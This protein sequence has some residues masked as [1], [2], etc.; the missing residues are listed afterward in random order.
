MIEGIL[1]RRVETR[2]RVND[3][4]LPYDEKVWI[5][6]YGLLLYGHFV[7]NRQQTY[8]EIVY[9]GK[10]R[11]Y[12]TYYQQCDDGSWRLVQAVNKK[13]EVFNPD[14]VALCK[15]PFSNNVCFMPGDEEGKVELIKERLSIGYVS[16]KS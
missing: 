3:F 2:R 10:K 1:D 5:P 6:D 8:M 4:G 16:H 13:G 9:E 12:E 11:V 14:E 15:T 7:L